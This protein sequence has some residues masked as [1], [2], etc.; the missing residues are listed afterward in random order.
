[1]LA[2]MSG[3]AGGRVGM[4]AWSRRAH[5]PSPAQA[6][7]GAKHGEAQSLAQNQPEDVAP[8][9]AERHANADLIR[10]LGDKAGDHAV[11]ANG[12]EQQ[13]EEREAGKQ[14]TGQRVGGRVLFD[15]LQRRADAAHRYFGID[16]GDRAAEGV[17]GAGALRNRA[18]RSIDPAVGDAQAVARHRQGA[19][20]VVGVIGLH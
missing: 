6:D 14:P 15:D 20:E 1:M 18:E 4:I 3:S 10:P 2:A 11:E 19:A 7:G 17:G 16:L 12:R 9:G 8:L 13:A 5:P